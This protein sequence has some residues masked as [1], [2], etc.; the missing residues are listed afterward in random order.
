MRGGP[1]WILVAAAVLGASKGGS[2]APLPPAPARTDLPVA[3]GWLSF[4]DVVR[5]ALEAGFKPDAAHLAARI[6]WRESKGNP[7]ATRIVTPEQAPRLK[8]LPER[9]F[10]L[11]QVNTVD[12]R[13]RPIRSDEGMLLDPAYNA[14]AA[15]ALSKGGTAWGPW[16]VH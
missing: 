11:W 7:G 16:R 15:Y 4:D 8:Q 6:A 14:A 2:W 9:S 13:G 1:W 3:P 12:E 10:G 5:V